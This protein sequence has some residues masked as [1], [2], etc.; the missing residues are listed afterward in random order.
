M[1]LENKKKRNLSQY[2]E[3]QGRFPGSRDA[4]VKKLKEK[5]RNWRVKRSQSSEER[6]SVIC[7][8]KSVCKG[9]EVWGINDILR[10]WKLSATRVWRVGADGKGLINCARDL[11]QMLRATYGNI[12]IFK[13]WSWLQRREWNRDLEPGSSGQ[14]NRLLWCKV[15]HT[16]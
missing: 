7:K 1:L 8:G 6:K 10:S 16:V 3:N 15:G 2:W 5:R 11:N 4:Q 12:C 13:R 9:P 14:I